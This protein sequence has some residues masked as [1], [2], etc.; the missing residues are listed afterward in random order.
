MSKECDPVRD[1]RR[2]TGFGFKF[3]SHPRERKYTVASAIIMIGRNI[4]KGERTATH[5]RKEAT[6]Y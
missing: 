2:G 1:R 4:H 3:R 5:L 6:Y